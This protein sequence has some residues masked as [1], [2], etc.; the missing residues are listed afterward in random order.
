MS[1][2]YWK[3]DQHSLMETEFAEG[4]SKFEPNVFSNRVIPRR[5]WWSH[6]IR[7]SKAPGK[8]VDEEAKA[9][10]IGGIPGVS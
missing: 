2:I 10:V 4:R 1:S 6:A 3:D 8:S 7:F 9:G 5:R